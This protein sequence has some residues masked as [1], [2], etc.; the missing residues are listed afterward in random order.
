M[1]ASTLTLPRRLALLSM[2]V[3]VAAAV[4]A[5]SGPTLDSPVVVTATR[6]AQPADEALL[7]VI[8]IDRDAIERSL[9][10]DVADLLR[11]HA[12]IDVGRNGGPG[13]AASLFIRGTNSDHAVVLVD[14]VRINPATL[15]A[16]PLQDI[17]PELV[18]H[19]EIVKGPRSTLYGTDAIGGVVNI[20]TRAPDSDRLGLVAGYGRYA[21]RQLVADGAL[22]GANGGVSLAV[23][24]FESAGFPTVSAS[25]IDRGYRNGSVAFAGRTTLGGVDAG[26]RLWSAAGNTQYSDYF[27]TPVDQDFVDTSFAVDAGTALTEYWHSHVTLS[28]V[29]D[30][31]HQKQ[32]PDFDDTRRDTLDWQNDLQLGPNTLTAGGILSH[33]HATTLVFGT[34]FDASI[35]SNTWYVEDQLALGAHRL[36]AAVGLTQHETF[37]DHTTWNAEYGYAPR[38]G[39]LLTAGAGTAFRAPNATDL[40]GY[41]GNPALRPESSRNVE[42]GARQRIGSHQTLALAAFENRV[43]ELLLFVYDPSLPDFG[44]ERNVGRARIRGVEASW[45]WRD[46]DWRARTELSRQQPRNLDDGTTLL[47]RASASATFALTRSFEQGELACDLRAVGPRD[48]FGGT[49]T[50]QLGGYLLANLAARLR[51]PHGFTLQARLENAL[52]RRYELVSGYN[53]P[54]RGLFI[55]TRYDLH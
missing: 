13:Q 9:A 42:L 22:A 18:D 28:R 39:T 40:Y 49:G 24:G 8:V 11:L 7:P 41:G 45:E 25:S 26:L 54:R 2:S 47:R 3:A 51:L 20:V 55:A 32:A 35:R 48:D 33:E 31:L 14:G 27:L 46:A 5:E 21:T 44:Q 10:P 38:E 34:G 23:S 37:G 29:V 1:Q 16:A 12:G 53:T 52:D 4:H 50:V 6:I 19:I 17:A 36:S 15:G 43:D 30:N